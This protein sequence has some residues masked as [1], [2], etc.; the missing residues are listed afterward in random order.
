MALIVPNPKALQEL[1]DSLPGVA[2]DWETICADPRV[3]AAALTQILAQA[4]SGQS[5][6]AV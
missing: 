4:K 6:P 1:A 3:T 2:G 5:I